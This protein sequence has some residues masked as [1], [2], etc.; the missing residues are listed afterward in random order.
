MEDKITT[1]ICVKLVYKWAI[2]FLGLLRRSARILPLALFACIDSSRSFGTEQGY[3]G[4]GYKA[5]Q[6]K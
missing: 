3:L 5:E 6:K 4:T 1:P 2:S